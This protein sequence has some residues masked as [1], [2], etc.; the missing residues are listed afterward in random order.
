MTPKQLA[1]KIRPL[2]AMPPLSTE[3]ER[4]LTKRGVWSRDG[5]WYTTQKQHW[6][7]WLKEYHGPGYYGRKN[8]RRSAEFAYNHIVCPPMVL[9]L[10]EAS[11]VPKATVAMAKKASSALNWATLAK[12]FTPSRSKISARVSSPI[13]LH[14]GHSMVSRTVDWV[15]AIV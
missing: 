1:A 6:L 4:V 11:G 10:G 14:N 12:S 3:Y 7:G 8:F 9:W 15:E 13:P 5:V 2:R